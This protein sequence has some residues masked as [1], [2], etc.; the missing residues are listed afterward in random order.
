VIPQLKGNIVA[1][2]AAN[3][4][5]ADD[6]AQMDAFVAGL[7]N[8]CAQYLGVDVS[9]GIATGITTVNAD[10]TG[11]APADPEKVYEMDELEGMNV[12]QLRTLAKKL[13]F[14]A[15]EVKTAG[16]K[17][18][19]AAIFA[20]QH[21]EGEEEPEPETE[22]EEVEDAEEEDS[23][24]E[25]GDEEEEDEEEGESEEDMRERLSGMSL[26]QVKKELK[27]FYAE[28]WPDYDVPDLAGLDKDSV[29]DMFFEEDEDADAEDPDEADEDAEDSEDEEAEGDE[30]EEED[31]EEE[32]N[33]TEE[34]LRAK[35][36][37]EL[38]AICREYGVK[39]LKSDDVDSLVKKLMA[40]DE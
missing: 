20:Y 33:Y 28:N 38:K 9:V 17:E 5:P 16:E 34:E 1:K 36:L 27:A 31:E 39:V 24:S 12:R 11:P 7:F 37:P 26:A 35:P 22:E 18:L 19:R 30:D 14:D 29:I 4:A 21:G 23:E 32:D 10:A 13:G 3:T 15:N 40:V 8:L 2:T 25:D 6:K